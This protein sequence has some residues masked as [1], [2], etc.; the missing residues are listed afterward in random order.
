MP[1]QKPL[2]LVRQ[3]LIA[4]PAPLATPLPSSRPRPWRLVAIPALLLALMGTAAALADPSPGLSAQKAPKS[5][6]EMPLP[7][8][9]PEPIPEDLLADAQRRYDAAVAHRRE[10]MAR[11]IADR[12]RVSKP[13]AKKIVDAAHDSG[14]RYHVDPLLLLAITAVESSFVAEARSPAGA[15]GLTQVLPRA[16]PEKLA[17]VRAAGKSPTDAATSLDLGAEVFREYSTRHRGDRIK[18]LQQYNGSLRDSSRRYSGKVMA[19]HRSLSQGLPALPEKP[20]LADFQPSL[21]AACQGPATERCEAGL[22]E[23]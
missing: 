13:V 20:T 9:L 21:P 4:H 18:A 22:P 11:R 3:P 15:I 5:T 19:V 17:R 6:E 16:H 10:E 12:Y 7:D 2:F 8:P 23:P 14:E 1:S